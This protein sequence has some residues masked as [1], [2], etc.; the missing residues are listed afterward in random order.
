MKSKSAYKFASMQL[1]LVMLF[2]YPMFFS[3]SHAVSHHLNKIHS[4]EIHCCEHSDHQ[5]SAYSYN[6]PG[7]EC[8]ILEYQFSLGIEPDVL[9]LNGLHLRIGVYNI[10]L[11]TG[12]YT[13]DEYT[14]QSPR[15]PPALV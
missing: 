8:P 5:E 2:T 11:T 6:L 15:A 12:F 9:Q 3:F 13:A 14:Q 1:I 10:P 7:E 4:H